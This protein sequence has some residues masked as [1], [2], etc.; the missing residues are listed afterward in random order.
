MQK[1]QKIQEL[2]IKKKMVKHQE[3]C[4]FEKKYKEYLDKQ[5]TLR[6]EN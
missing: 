4:Q 5:E 1:R 3:I 2:I 6:K